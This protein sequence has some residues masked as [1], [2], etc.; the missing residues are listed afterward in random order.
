MAGLTLYWQRVDA[1]TVSSLPRFAL[2][3]SGKYLMC[4]T[5][6]RRSVFSCQFSVATKFVTFLAILRNGRRGVS[7]VCIA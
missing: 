3:V 7:G 6:E 2:C 4:Q 1:G 5:R